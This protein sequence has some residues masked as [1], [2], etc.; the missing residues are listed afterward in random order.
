[1]KNIYRGDFSQLV[2]PYTYTHQKLE[3][4]GLKG[5]FLITFKK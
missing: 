3:R 5:K 1:M 2:T 4:K